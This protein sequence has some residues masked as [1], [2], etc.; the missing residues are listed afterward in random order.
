MNG[1]LDARLGGQRSEGGCIVRVWAALHDGNTGPMV[2]VDDAYTGICTC[3]GCYSHS[4]SGDAGLGIARDRV[5]AI[6]NQVAMRYGGSNGAAGLL[7]AGR[8][9]GDQ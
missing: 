8:R 3:S 2:Y 9:E 7:G 4:Y 5:V 1:E 6:H